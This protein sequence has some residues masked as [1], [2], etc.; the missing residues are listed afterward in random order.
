M[1][2]GKNISENIS[3]VRDKYHRRRAIEAGEEY[4]I[5]IEGVESSHRYTYIYLNVMGEIW[6]LKA[7]HRSP[8]R[9]DSLIPILESMTVSVP[10]FSLEDIVGSEVTVTF[11]E[12][13]NSASIGDTSYNIELQDDIDLGDMSE[14]SQEDIN[15]IQRTAS[16]WY[17]YQKR[18]EDEGWKCTV[19]SSEA[20]GEDSIRLSVG[21]DTNYDLDWVFEIPET[22]ESSSNIRARL[23][24][25]VGNGD[26][27]FI[28]DED[29]VIVHQRE[30]DGYLPTIG[31]DEVTGDWYLTTPQDYIKWKNEELSSQNHSRSR[32]T[33]SKSNSRP[34]TGTSSSQMLRKSIK[35]L[36]MSSTMLMAQPMID[37]M[38]IEPMDDTAKTAE[39]MEVYNQMMNTLEVLIFFMVTV[40]LIM[41]AVSVLKQ[42]AQR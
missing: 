21:T 7:N 38:M 13:M 25:E 39:F 4:D 30:K 6:K 37:N 33:S 17:Q 1:E 22:T 35:G 29:V 11:D 31:K 12:N 9:D 23:I 41:L 34:T 16:R 18:S 36:L 27:F 14:S 10:Y 8:W 5:Q 20:E 32:T 3:E 24:E 19:V 2:F 26:P 40:S 15:K 28:E 42:G